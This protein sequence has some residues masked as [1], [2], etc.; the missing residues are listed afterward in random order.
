MGTS[1]IVNGRYSTKFVSG[2]NRYSLEICQRL[3][4]KI[5]Y[6]APTK[7]SSIVNGIPWEQSYLPFLVGSDDLL[8]SPGNTGPLGV[9]NQVVTIHDLIPLEHPE[10]FKSSFSA[11]YRFLLPRLSNR[12][13]HII[14]I[15]EFSKERISTILGI[16]PEK[17]TIVPEGVGDEFRQENSKRIMDVQQKY[18]IPQ[19][20]LLVVSSLEPRKNLK[21][22]LES[23]EIIYQRYQ[24]IELAIVGISRYSPRD[25]GFSKLPKGVNLIGYVDDIDL[26]AVY[27]GAIALIFPSIY[28]GFGLPVLEAMACGTPV[29]ASNTS[30]LPEVIG[31]AGLLF[32]PFE[33]DDITSSI[34]KFLHDGELREDL[35]EKGFKQA[36]KFSWDTTAERVW[37]VLSQTIAE[38]NS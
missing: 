3:G 9:S 7:F 29:I 20:Y 30:S 38:I 25:V 1:V 19:K 22:L 31:D 2:I 12:A 16:L 23:W 4:G 21:R 34:E 15:S 18:N 17:I 37:A 11:W 5:K 13:M 24:D 26:P 6:C 36:T 8:W 32:D 28:E 10:W 27:S 35:R 33:I 14:T